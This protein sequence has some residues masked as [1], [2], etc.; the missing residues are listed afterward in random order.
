MGPSE[1]IESTIRERAAR[2]ERFHQRINRCHVVIDIPHRH[3][4]KG[5]HYAVRIDI[6]TPTREISVTR[7]PPADHSHE[8]F[9]VALR[10]AFD[11][12]TRQLEDEVRRVRGD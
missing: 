7:D 10:D 1:A 11:A 9:N 6:T 2:L 12:A 5:G 4:R 3:H 8:E